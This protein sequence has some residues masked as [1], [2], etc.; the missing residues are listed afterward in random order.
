MREDRVKWG[1]KLGIKMSK[2]QHSTW[3]TFENLHHQLMPTRTR[4]ADSDGMREAK[5]N[6]REERWYFHFTGFI[7]QFHL[8][9]F[10]KWFF[11]NEQFIVILFP[12]KLYQRWISFSVSRSS[13]FFFVAAARHCAGQPDERWM[14]NLSTRK[15]N[16][17]AWA[18]LFNRL[19]L[20]TFHF[21]SCVSVPVVIFNTQQHVYLSVPLSLSSLCVI[22]ICFK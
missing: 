21:S 11:W 15:P 18:H 20:S 14:R 8:T 9:M 6:E 1:R 7:F 2:E 22:R 13:T 12:F 10:E 5:I 17:F 16:N 19:G 3:N 4:R